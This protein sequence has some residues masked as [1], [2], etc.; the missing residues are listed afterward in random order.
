MI[1][2][3]LTISVVCLLVAVHP[4]ITYPL[5]LLIIRAVQRRGARRALARDAKGGEAQA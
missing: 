2:V 5:S 1:A 3:L 4:F